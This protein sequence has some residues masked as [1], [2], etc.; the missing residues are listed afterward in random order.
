LR[1]MTRSRHSR[2]IEPMARSAKGFCQGARGDDE[3]VNAHV[4][5]SALEVR[6]VEGVAIAEQVGGSGL[7]G[8]G[9]DDL[10]GGWFS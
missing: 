3:L 8:G 2:R 1:T 4:L 7:V 9:V 10:L 6:T 5:H